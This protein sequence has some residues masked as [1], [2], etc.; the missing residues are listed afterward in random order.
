MN[1][2]SPRDDPKSFLPE[3][4]RSSGL[5]MSVVVALAGLTLAFLVQFGGTIWWGATLAA[6]VQNIS[7]AIAKMDGERYT[8]S[9]AQRD[10]QRLDERDRS[11][12]ELI[13]DVKARLMRLEELRK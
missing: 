6:N 3:R 7:M 10:I 4:R 13:A 9:D 1:E 12:T 8:R 5:N 2:E 11:L